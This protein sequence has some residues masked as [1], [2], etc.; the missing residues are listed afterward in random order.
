[1]QVGVPN[2]IRREVPLL[3]DVGGNHDALRTHAVLTIEITRVV[4]QFW[5]PKITIRL[6]IPKLRVIIII[7]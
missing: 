4:A 1:M 7:K 3:N 2:R 5:L 6:S